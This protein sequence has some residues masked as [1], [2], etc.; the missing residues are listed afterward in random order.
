MST[1]AITLAEISPNRPV[2]VA[3]DDEGGG[4]GLGG[5]GQADSETRRASDIVSDP[6]QHP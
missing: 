6:S 2:R 3:V 5:G 4:D 1:K